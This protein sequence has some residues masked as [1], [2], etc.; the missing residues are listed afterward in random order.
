MRYS[1]WNCNQMIKTK[2]KVI[3]TWRA[4][5]NQR[6]NLAPANIAAPTVTTAENEAMPKK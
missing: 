2:A 6:L 5:Q 4:C 1:D 3:P